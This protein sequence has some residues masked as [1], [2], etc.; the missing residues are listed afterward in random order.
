MKRVVQVSCGRQNFR[1]VPDFHLN[2]YRAPALCWVAMVKVLTLV[3][4]SFLALAPG[5]DA[6]R[7]LHAL[8]LCTFAASHDKGGHSHDSH[9]SHDKEHSGTAPQECPALAEL[10]QGA[11]VLNLEPSASIELAALPS[12]DFVCDSG[13]PGCTR[14]VA[15]HEVRPPPWPPRA[16]GVI[17]LI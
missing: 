13:L 9:H 11:P 12:L 6:V 4:A 7:A 15:V 3:V 17:L 14:G 2:P 10:P 8:E 5:M 1:T 16:G